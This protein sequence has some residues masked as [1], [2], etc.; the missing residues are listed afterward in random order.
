MPHLALQ[1]ALRVVGLGRGRSHVLLGRQISGFLPSA[2]LFGT[3][4]SSGLNGHRQ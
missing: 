4:E 2:S 3:S 1:L